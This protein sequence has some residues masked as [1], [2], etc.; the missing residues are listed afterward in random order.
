LVLVEVGAQ[1]L[2]EFWEKLV[3]GAI[4]EL[5]DPGNEVTGVRVIHKVR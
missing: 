1:E 4:G 5:I 2:D 3:L